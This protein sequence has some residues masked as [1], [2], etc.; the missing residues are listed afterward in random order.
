MTVIQLAKSLDISYGSANSILHDNLRLSK[1]SAQW[2]P[3]ALCPDQLILRSDLSLAI[4]NKIEVNEEHFLSRI[5]TGDET[6]IYQYDPE[7]KQQSKQWL[8]RGSSG[9]IKFKSQKSAQKVM[10]TIFWDSDGVILIDY[11][12]GQRTVTGAYYANVLRKLKEAL[13]RKRKGKLHG[14]I[15]FHHD[16]APAHS[17]RVAKE[18]LREFRWEV[19]PHPPYSPDLAP[20]DFFLFPKLKEMLKGTH[21]SDVEE[22]KNTANTWLQTSPSTFFR[23]SLRSWKHR[24]EKCLDLNGNYVEK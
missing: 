9:P 2:V 10:A 22:A 14:G 21:F 8:P 15:L 16:N 1:L 18:V 17:V 23:D 13:V 11:L 19:L 5:I 4:L 24:L 6:W 12:K 20:S 7:S 3:K